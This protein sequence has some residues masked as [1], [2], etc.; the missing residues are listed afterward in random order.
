MFYRVYVIAAFLLGG[1]ATVFAT[2]GELLEYNLVRRFPAEELKAFF[3]LHH[4]PKVV[5]PVNHGLNI[6]EVVYN[7]YY[8]DSSIVKASGLL[9][10]PIVEGKNM[11]LMIYNHGTEMCRDRSCSFTGEQSICLAFATDG[12]IVLTPD[13]V[14]MG[15]GER[16]QLYMNAF[17]ESHASVDMLTA[18]KVL[19][20]QLDVNTNKQLFVTGYS[21][22]GHA[23]MATSRLLQTEYADQYPVT[24]ASP[25]SGPYDLESTVYNGRKNDYEYPGFFMLLL[26]SY[27]ESTGQIEKMGEAL[28]APYR[29]EIPPLIT[30][31]YPV[32]EIDKLLPDTVMKA[33]TEDFLTQ[34]END[35]TSGFRKYLHDNNVNDWIPEMPMKLCYCDADEEVNY[36]NSVDTYARMK[37]NGAKK[38]VLWRVGKKF[39]H[40]N[41]AQ[42]AVIYTKMFF[43]GFRHGKPGSHGPHFERMLLNIGKLSVP[44]R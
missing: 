39:G 22:G 21:Q 3:K 34:F 33:V 44:A 28:K 16:D 13:Y 26:Q 17:T 41:C 35:S 32:Q 23:A 10:V 40:V 24:A 27:Y 7:T 14:G 38:V 19:L 4:I 37:A 2:T 11:P 25:M 15:K 12:Y 36:K 43:D 42:F 5:L 1:C 31:N 20:K 18:A 6:Y 30:G 9:Y 29:T 8:A